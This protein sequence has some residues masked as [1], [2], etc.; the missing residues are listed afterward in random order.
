[1]IKVLSKSVR[2]YKTASILSPV[3]VSLEV[4]LECLIPF[5]IAQLVNAIDVDVAAGEVIKMS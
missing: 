1:M 2:E 3:F 5:I 4:V